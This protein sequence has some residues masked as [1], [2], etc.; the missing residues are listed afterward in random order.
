[1]ADVK[2]VGSAL[3]DRLFSSILIFGVVFLLIVVVGSI[4]FYLLY[5]RKK[6]NMTVKI[7]SERS[8]DPEI[9]FDKAAIIRDWKTKVK[10]F[11]LLDT[12]V[13]LQVPPFKVI[14]KTSK[15]DYIELWR[16][17]EEEFVFLTPPRIDR[18]RVIKAN[19]RL[20]KVADSE[21]KQ[22]EGDL[23]WYFTRKER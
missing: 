12:K 9:Y 17:S 11:K 5:W 19:G 16:K 18:V 13:E 4:M 1:M 7:R 20:Y 14:E 6:F 10:Y 21:Q 8:Q 15:G 3:A 2:E 22:I 23:D